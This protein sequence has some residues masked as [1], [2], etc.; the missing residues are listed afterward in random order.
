MTLVPAGAAAGALLMDLAA[1]HHIPTSLLEMARALISEHE[2]KAAFGADPAGYLAEHGFGDLSGPEA[3]VAL[4]HV[5]DALPPALARALVDGVPTEGDAVARF[6]AAAAVDGEAAHEQWS[7]LAEDL[8]R[9]GDL[10]DPADPVGID[11][12]VSAEA[13]DDP[14]DIDEVVV[15]TEAASDPDAI[16]DVAPVDGVAGEASRPESDRPSHLGFGEGAATAP[17]DPTG[18]LRTGP[19]SAPPGGLEDTAAGHSDPP[20]PPVV[21][22]S[23]PL[24]AGVDGPEPD[25]E[26]H[27]SDTAAEDPAEW[28][29]SDLGA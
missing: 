4:D 12:M 27:S 16:A 13:T 8:P 11:D 26:Q 24:A 6:A 1:R 18:G 14:A 2:A 25:Q 21:A 5:G 10:D 9:V 23:D 15:L 3:A 22:G 19:P 20:D 7:E 29:G 17:G 28:D